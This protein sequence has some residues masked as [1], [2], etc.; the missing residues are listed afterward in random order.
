M[1]NIILVG[2]N[3]KMG[4]V[5]S[6]IVADDAD[7]NIVCGVDISAEAKNGFPVYTSFDEITDTDSV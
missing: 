1:I 6:R 7:A 4:Q 5:I 3:G 2:V